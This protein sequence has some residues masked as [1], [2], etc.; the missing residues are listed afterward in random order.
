MLWARPLNYY[1]ALLASHT[2]TANQ[3]ATGNMQSNTAFTNCQLLL[4]DPNVQESD[5]TGDAIGT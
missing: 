4:T 5:T 1:L 3:F 2:C